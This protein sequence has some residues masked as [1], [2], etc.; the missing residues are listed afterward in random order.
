M[1]TL[2]AFNKSLRSNQTDAE[3]LLWYRLRARRFFNYKF[4]RQVVLGTYI[5]DFVC[6]SRKLILELDGGQHSA[7]ESYDR[8]RTQFLESEGFQVLR[9]WNHD[10][11]SNLDGVLSEILKAIEKR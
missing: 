10:V 6:H 9:F 8:K 5:V 2:T 1:K 11:M 4:R 7:A 3:Q